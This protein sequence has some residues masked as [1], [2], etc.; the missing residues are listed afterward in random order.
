MRILV[1]GDIPV[2]LR[3]RVREATHVFVGLQEGQPS[4]RIETE[5]THWRPVQ[6]GQNAVDVLIQTLLL[7]RVKSQQSKREAQCMRCGL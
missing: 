1:L 7:I 5:R 3:Q 4:V 2:D 6:A